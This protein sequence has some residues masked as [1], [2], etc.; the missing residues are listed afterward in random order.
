MSKRMV[1]VAL[2]VALAAASGVTSAGTWFSYQRAP[3]TVPA[4]PSVD[5]RRAQPW[6]NQRAIYSSIATK[7]IIA[8]HAQ[9]GTACGL[10]S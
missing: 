2:A 8:A 1:C 9:L 5:S 10:C 7:K 3:G 6:L 4:S